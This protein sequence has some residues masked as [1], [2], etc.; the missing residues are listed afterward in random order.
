MTAVAGG[1]PGR[2]ACRMMSKRLLHALP[3][4]LLAHAAAAQTSET[5][6]A[7]CRRPA[8]PFVPSGSHDSIKTMKDATADLRTYFG[9]MNTYILCLR[10]EYNRARAEAEQIQA[11][12]KD[13]QARFKAR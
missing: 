12:W 8:A 2:L 1:A 3:L 5:G 13:A 9:D 6:P 11:Q 10:N 4:V 7:D